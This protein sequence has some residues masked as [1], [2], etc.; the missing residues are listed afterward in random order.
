M[1]EP[2]Q[3]PIPAEHALRGF[4]SVSA[5]LEGLR[6]NGAI[7]HRQFRLSFDRRIGKPISVCSRTTRRRGRIV[8]LLCL[9]DT[10]IGRVAAGSV[11]HI[12]F[13]AR[14]STNNSSGAKRLVALG[15]NV[16]PVIDRTYFHSIYFR[17]PGDVLLKSDRAAR[18]HF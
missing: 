15:Y 1:I 9:P 14:M 13:R 12:A 10:G 3:Q 4:H 16:T 18:F 11:H 5:A 2:R 6:E 17:E 8:D 7:T